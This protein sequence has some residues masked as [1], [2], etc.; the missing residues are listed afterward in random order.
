MCWPLGEG[1]CL[2]EGGGGWAWAGRRAQLAQG[3][4]PGRQLVA[5]RPHPHSPQVSCPGF[6]SAKSS[7]PREPQN[8]FKVASVAQFP[9]AERAGWK[10][11]IYRVNEGC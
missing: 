3:N 8:P 2:S 5:L 1:S 11:D 10:I 4:L 7:G 9:R 6:H